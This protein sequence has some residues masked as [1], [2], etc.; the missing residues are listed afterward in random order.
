MPTPKYTLCKTKFGPQDITIVIVNANSVKGKH[1]QLI[2]LISTTLPHILIVT[3]TKLSIKIGSVEF[4]NTKI[5]SEIR[6]D[7]NAKGGGIPIVIANNLE[8]YQT[9]SNK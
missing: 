8:D 5:Y 7:R 1:W 2:S 9:E 4:I 6:K 3:E